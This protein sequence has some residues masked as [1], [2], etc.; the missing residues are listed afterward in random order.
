MMTYYNDT[1]WSASCGFIMRYTLK[2]YQVSETLLLNHA[3]E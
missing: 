1:Q 2:Y 3:H